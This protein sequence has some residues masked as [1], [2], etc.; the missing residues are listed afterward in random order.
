MD[1]EVSNLC[2]P[3]FLSIDDEQGKY[4]RDLIDFEEQLLPSYNGSLVPIESSFIHSEVTLSKCFDP[5]KECKPLAFQSTGNMVIGVLLL[6][7]MV[8]GN[9]M[10]GP[11]SLKI[12][13]DTVYLK[14]TWRTQSVCLISCSIMILHYILK[15]Q[16]L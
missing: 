6:F 14:A 1:S 3:K 10:I 7:Q 16:G 8:I 2:I 11:H 15:G 13:N 4:L 9:W 5:N 12:P